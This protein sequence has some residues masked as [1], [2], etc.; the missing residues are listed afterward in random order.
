M[1]TDRTYRFDSITLAQRKAAAGQAPCYMYYF[2]WES[3]V[4]EGRAL[5]HHAL[6]I[7]FA[8]DNTSKAPEMS[9]GGKEA[10]ALAAKMSEA[11]IRF[12]RGGDPNSPWLPEWPAYSAPRRAT[13]VLDNDCAVVE[14]PDA[15]VRRLW[16]TV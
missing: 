11:W 2:A 16:A 3:P 8:F 15:E 6:E 9:G 12:A 14:D 13:M 10:A 1:L 4:D 5:A 7:S